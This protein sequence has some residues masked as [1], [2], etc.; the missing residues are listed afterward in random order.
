MMSFSR[1]ARTEGEPDI[2]GLMEAG[3]LGF[4]VETT[5]VH[6]FRDTNLGLSLAYREEDGY[7]VPP[8]H[9]FARLLLRKDTIKVAHNASFDRNMMKRVGIN[10][11]EN[12]ICTQVAAHLVQNATMREFRDSNNRFALQLHDA[13]LTLYTQSIKHCGMIVQTYSGLGLAEHENLDVSTLDELAMYSGPH[14]IATLKLWKVL[15]KK[16]VD[17]NVMH[18]FKEIEM[19]F[20]PVLADIE[21]N[22]VMVD[23]KILNDIE[24]KIE[25]KLGEAVENLNR[26]AGVSEMNHNSS[27]QVSWLLY[28]K[29]GVKKP[30]IKPKEDSHPSVDKRILENVKK[31]HPYIIPYLEY[32]ELMTLRNSYTRSLRKDICSDG[33]IYGNLNQTG[34]ATSRLSS[35]NPNLQKIPVRTELGKLIRTAF[36]APEGSVIVKVDWDQ[37]ELRMAAFIALVAGLIDTFAQGRDPHQE[38]GDKAF[39]NMFSPEDRRTKGKTKNFQVVYGGGSIAEKKQLDAMYPELGAWKDKYLGNRARHEG[40]IGYGYAYTLGGRKRVLPELRHDN[41]RMIA[42]GG[43]EAVSTMVQGTSSEEV[44]KGMTRCWQRTKNTEIKMILQVHDE[45]DFECPKYLLPDLIEIVMDTAPAYIERIGF[46]G[47]LISIPL[48]VGIEIGDSWGNV[49]ALTVLKRDPIIHEF[50][51]EKVFW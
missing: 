44:K 31:D 29:L 15:E 6:S 38:T 23:V 33:R 32:K 35:S 20:L 24:D 7:Y 17:E 36:V 11:D 2:D 18:T 43:R 41:G 26:L 46:D 14:S 10:I 28:E 4:D 45:M 47:K 51:P 27:Q 50:F 25:G 49:Q 21:Y 3:I 1:I 34:T 39:G 16:L 12:I 40:C 48:S 42:A 13:P 37:L 30:K 8:E 22:G 5:G 19:P 9:P